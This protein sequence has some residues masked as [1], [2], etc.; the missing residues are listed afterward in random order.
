MDRQNPQVGVCAAVKMLRLS[1]RGSR[2]KTPSK[3]FRH[4][5]L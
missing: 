1:A 5:V 2:L 3:G 4:N